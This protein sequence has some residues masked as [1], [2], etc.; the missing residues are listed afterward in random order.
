MVALLGVVVGAAGGGAQTAHHP[1]DDMTAVP[2][3]VVVVGTDSAEVPGLM[4]RFDIAHAGLFAPEV[5]RRSVRLAGFLIDRHEVTNAEFAAF[6]RAVPAWSP[7]HIRPEAHN[8]AYLRHWAN[9]RPPAGATNEPVVYVS[10]Y[11]ADAYC[12]WAGKRLPTEA[13]WEHAAR[14]GLAGE[15][16]PWGEAM[17][18]STRVN[19]SGSGIGRPVPVG[20]YPPNGYGLYDM[21]GNV[22][23]Y[24]AD[25][26]VEGGGPVRDSTVRRVIRG[27]SFGG[28]AVNLRVRYGDSHPAVGAGPHGGFRCARAG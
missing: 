10:W 23:E 24:T 28:A 5:P 21:A 13:E 6:V 7:D 12:R 27:G 15:V 17:P 4:A 14:G 9:G 2:G 16:F 26:W 8:G 25:P 18:D 3:G 11:A 20:R 1:G 19:W 22:W